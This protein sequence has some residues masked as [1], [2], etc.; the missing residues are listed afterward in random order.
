[1]LQFTHLL[2]EAKSK[3]STNI[4]PYA[5]THDI[6]ESVDGFSQISLNYNTFPPIK[7]KTKPMIFI[8]E[9]R[10]DVI[11][12]ELPKRVKIKPEAKII[13]EPEIEE[14]EEILNRVEKQIKRKLPHV[15]R[16]VLEK[17]TKT[18]EE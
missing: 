10:L 7:I 6:L 9:R 2:V 14:K 4:R 17:K 13:L 16:S 8:L 11:V 12:P 18:F 1:M 5:K 3:Y 15:L